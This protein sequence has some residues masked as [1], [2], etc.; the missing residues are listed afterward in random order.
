MS[1]SSE[2]AAAIEDEDLQL[3]RPRKL[4]TQTQQLEKSKEITAIQ[5]MVSACSGS[6]ITSLVVT[7][8]DV[9][10]IRVQQQEVMLNFECCAQAA[11]SLSSSASTSSKFATSAST[12]PA[13]ASTLQS[14]PPGVFWLDH[15][16]CESAEEFRNYRLD[17]LSQSEITS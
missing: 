9:V 12:A 16:Y 4:P 14:S 2:L 1:L 5:R 13:T 10:R 8:F 15:H 11:S 3:R 7:P 17:F 6:F